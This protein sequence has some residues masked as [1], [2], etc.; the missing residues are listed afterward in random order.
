[1]DARYSRLARYAGLAGTLPRWQAACCAVVG[2]GGLGGGLVQQLARL[3]VKR[4]VLIDRDVA[5][6]EN[7]G[8]QAL[9]T[10]ED[11]RQGLPKAVAAGRVAQAVNPAVAV[12]A[13]VAELTRQNID[14]LLG[15][16]EL[17][18]DGLD[19][20]FTR[21][22]LNDYSHATGKPYFYAGVVRGELS[23]RAVIPGVTGCLRC[24]LDAPP[25]PGQAP[26]CAAAGVFPPLLG[27]AN[28]LQLDAAN[29][30]LGG[31][32][33]AGDDVLVSLTLPGWQWRTLALGGPRAECPVC[34]QGRY[35]YL[36]GERDALARQ[37]CT[38]G[39]VEGALPSAPLDL[40]RARALLA[41]AGGFG[42]RQNPYCVVAERGGL[43]YTLFASG[44][45]VLEGS[46]DPAELSR[47]VAT[48]LGC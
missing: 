6:E 41:A 8:H 32:F 47:F 21:F 45:L 19:N 35:E 15:A 28:A 42:L 9:F 23:A 27:V 40:A 48:Y 34:V 43:R 17:L 44:R 14:E 29:R 30:Y 25:A 11:A 3:G 26:T 46:D 22:L 33:T 10:A 39:R 16:A 36:S 37:A 24:L 38:E 7:L 1:M 12:D 5:G 13:H 31:E 4:L 2:L 20:Y 18:F